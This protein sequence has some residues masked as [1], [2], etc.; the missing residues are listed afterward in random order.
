[1]AGSRSRQVRGVHTTDHAIAR[2]TVLSAI[3]PPSAVPCL[4]RGFR[5]AGH[6]KNK[7]QGD[8]VEED[9]E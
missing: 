2:P 7:A 3:D 9:V 6:S 1:M 5:S 4:I 8:A